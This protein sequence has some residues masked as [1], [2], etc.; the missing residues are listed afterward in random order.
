MNDL[1]AYTLVDTETR[2]IASHFVE[3]EFQISV[4]RPLLHPGDRPTSYPVLYLF[5]A[6]F[7]FGGITE[8]I[9]LMRKC[10]EF[11]VTMVVGIGYPFDG[12]ANEMIDMVVGWRMRDFTPVVSPKAEQEILQGS[13][14]LQA[15]TSGGADAFYQFV[16]QEVIPLVEAAYPIDPA[17]RTFMGHSWGGVFGLYSLFR[18]PLLFKNY[19][20]CSPDLPYGDGILFKYEEAYAQT[21]HSLPAKLFISQGGRETAEDNQ[22]F[23]SILESR[24]YNDLSITHKSI[25]ACEHCAS[26]MPSFVAG[27]KAVFD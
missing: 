12:P 2:R 13:P 3:Q 6:N 15:V 7:Y 19:L 5:D 26:P 16:T 4:A 25:M 24:G 22:R 17:N 20:I 10:N 11:P 21:H 9:R 14:T 27:L 23:V 1:P 8:V 18:D